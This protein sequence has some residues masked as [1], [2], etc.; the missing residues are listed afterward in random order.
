MAN[1]INKSSLLFQLPNLTSLD[2]LSEGDTENTNSLVK[3]DIVNPSEYILMNKSN[4]YFNLNATNMNPTRLNNNSSTSSLA[5]SSN[6]SSVSSCSSSSSFNSM[7]SNNSIKMFQMANNIDLN[8]QYNDEMMIRKKYNNG[9][10]RTTSSL[11]TSNGGVFDVKSHVLSPMTQN[12][13]DAKNNELIRNKSSF[14]L[15]F[16]NETNTIDNLN[17]LVNTALKS[18]NDHLT[19]PDDLQIDPPGRNNLTDIFRKRFN[20]FTSDIT[21]TKNFN[22]NLIALNRIDNE[23]NS[24][25]PPPTPQTQQFYRD[26]RHNSIIGNSNNSV[27]PNNNNQIKEQR[28]FSHSF[29]NNNYF[30]TS[31]NILQPK[32]VRPNEITYSKSLPCLS[33][34]CLITQSNNNQSNINNK[35]VKFAC[36]SC[37]TVRFMHQMCYDKYIAMDSFINVTSSL[38]KSF[39]ISKQLNQVIINCNNCLNGYLTIVFSNNSTTNNQGN[40]NNNNNSVRKKSFC[41]SNPP[42]PVPMQSVRESRSPSPANSLNRS[43]SNLLFQN[44]N[45]NQKLI[46]K[47]S[48]PVNMPKSNNR[49]R[50]MSTGSNSSFSAASSFSSNIS[51]SLNV[52]SPSPSMTNGPTTTSWKKNKSQSNSTLNQTFSSSV[53][54]VVESSVNNLTMNLTSESNLKSDADCLTQMVSNMVNKLK[55]DD[56]K[57][58]EDKLAN[59]GNIF[60]NRKEWL[61]ILNQLPLDKQNGIHIRL[62]DDGPYGND[63]TR[64]FVLSHFSKLCIREMRCI[65]CDDK[66]SIYDKF[67]LVDGTLYMSP[68]KYSN[69]N[70][71][72]IEVDDKRPLLFVEANISNKHQFIYAVC[73][74][75]L[76]S[77]NNHIIKCKCCKLEWKGGKSL[78]VGTLYK[79][80]IFSPFLCCQSRLNCSK[81]LMPIVN[82]KSNGGL[83]YF[84]SYSEE[85]ECFYCKTVDYHLIKPLNQ[86]FD[87]EI[88]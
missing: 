72:E 78:Q 18:D 35:L 3:F 8:N 45:M 73:L 27:L 5:S 10:K 56:S 19:Q 23:L 33:K 83:P 24:F 40:N 15:N 58:L 32:Y 1:E 6:S 16:F 62:E 50:T 2:E 54:T 66:M 31:N 67:P 82:L 43:Q 84:S 44:T 76:H 86:I 71:N 75:C 14:S 37:Q 68:V 11:S 21:S 60:Y 9:L 7:S 61:T 26:Y 70:S 77:A 4:Q 28:A 69:Q 59:S 49:F 46:K 20:S 22:D 65:L 51:N 81:C 36:N 57:C 34:N 85:K 30:D 42:L 80:E 29:S 47:Q 48:A 63:D 25:S 53:I 12:K 88:T 17:S 41:L 55:L 39:E 79:F 87:L 74:N 52:G 13:N 64:V 38:S